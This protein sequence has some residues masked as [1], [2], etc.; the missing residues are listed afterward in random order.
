MVLFYYLLDA[1]AV[2]IGLNYYARLRVFSDLIAW[3]VGRQ[4]G[5]LFNVTAIVVFIGSMGYSVIRE[6]QKGIPLKNES[7]ISPSSL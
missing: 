5:G 3:S 7:P 6:R 2:S 4:W 1:S